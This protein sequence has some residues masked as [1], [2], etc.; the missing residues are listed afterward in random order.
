MKELS[1]FILYQDI[2]W[3]MSQW[4]NDSD[5]YS[6]KSTLKFHSPLPRFEAEKEFNTFIERNNRQNASLQE[7]K[8]GSIEQL[9]INTG[10]PDNIEAKENEISSKS[11]E[12]SKDLPDTGGYRFVALPLPAYQSVVQIR[13]YIIINQKLIINPIPLDL[14]DYNHHYIYPE[15]I[16]SSGRHSDE[17]FLSQDEKKEMDNSESPLEYLYAK[18]LEEKNKLTKFI[19]ESQNI[20]TKQLAQDVLDE[21]IGWFSIAKYLNIEPKDYSK[22]PTDAGQPSSINPEVENQSKKEEIQEQIIPIQIRSSITDIARIFDCMKRAGIIES[23]IHPKKIAQIFFDSPKEKKK[24]ANSLNARMVD[25][26]NSQRNSNSNN[27]L[28]FIKILI[29]QSFSKKSNYLEK[30]SKYIDELRDK[31]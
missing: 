7:D 11:I 9:D 20:R 25:I 5:G 19:E 16:Q 12:E 26:S 17:I 23:V 30:M 6:K 1:E 28:E 8:T 10:Q 21:F 27:L 18:N 24:L 2:Y 13:K 15:S 31:V 29:E 4:F 3:E 22:F 14:D